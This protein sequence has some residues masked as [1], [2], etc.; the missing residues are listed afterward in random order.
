MICLSWP[1]GP[2]DGGVCVRA[3]V[4]SDHSGGQ[5]GLRGR[6]RCRFQ[7]GV[8]EP[9]PCGAQT[10]NVINPPHRATMSAMETTM[11]GSDIGVVATIEGGLD[12]RT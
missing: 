11:R 4:I 12:G 2:L 3:D 1:G 6:L 10:A 5:R 9:A 8:W 7:P